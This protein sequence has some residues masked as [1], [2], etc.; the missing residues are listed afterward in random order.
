M[1]SLQLT[2]AEWEALEDEIGPLRLPRAYCPLE[3]TLKQEWFL[4]RDELE[5]FFGG[6]AGPGKSYG[7]LMA[8]LQYVDVPGYHGLLLRPQLNEFEQP[9]GLIEASHDWLDT[10]SAYWNGTKRQW[11]FPSGATL[12]FGYLANQSDLRQYK[13]PS[14]SFCGFD[15]IT[16]FPEYLYRAMF[17]VLRQARGLLDNVPLRM[18]AASNPGDIGHHWVKARFITKETRVKDA[19]FV[20]ATIHDNPYLDY[21]EYLKSLAHLSPLD[22]ARLINGDWDVTEEGGKFHREQFKIVEPEEVEAPTASVR[23]WDLAGSEPSPAYPNP[24][25]TVG[26]K[27]ERAASGVFTLRHIVRGRWADHVVERTVHRTAEEDG[28][29]VPVYIEKDP[30]Q[31][32]KAQVSHYKRHV[33]AGYA[34]HSGLTR[35]DGKNNASKELRAR[36]VA[37]AVGNDLVQ[38]VS[39]CPNLIEF[40]DEVSIFPNGEFDDM[41]DAFSG[42]HNAITG[43]SVGRGRTSVPRGRLPGV[44][45]RIPAR[46]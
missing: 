7:L 25:F 30:G 46:R 24:D 3:P 31:A 4:R 43:R 45:D 27:L 16:G 35:V 1:T 8:G 18:R 37:A 23:Y 34:C 44:D 22:Q 6:A 41:V 10:T 5:A 11:A 17:R 33:L 15:E 12:R 9:G 20:P 13:G 26:L 39:T 19:I 38:I 40:L 36:P 28:R 21:V 14:Y 42:A 29:P 32:G 2:D